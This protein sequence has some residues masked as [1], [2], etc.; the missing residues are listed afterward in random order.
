M[1]SHL[2]ARAYEKTWESESPH[3]L[4]E[5]R[6]L[7]GKESTEEPSWTPAPA[8]L[9]VS[10]WRVIKNDPLSKEQGPLFFVGI[11]VPILVSR[12]RLIGADFI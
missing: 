12:A 8:H 6:T 9:T 3:T 5:L 4:L 2:G 7:I 1:K 11:S 10:D